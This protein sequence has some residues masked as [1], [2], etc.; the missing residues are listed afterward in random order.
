MEVHTKV[1]LELCFAFA[2]FWIILTWRCFRK[3]NPSSVAN[4]TESPPGVWWCK[5]GIAAATSC[6]LQA[7]ALVLKMWLL[8]LES[9]CFAKRHSIRS[10]QTCERCKEQIEIQTCSLL[11]A[12]ALP[13]SLQ[14][15]SRQGLR[16]NTAGT[17][18]SSTWHVLPFFQHVSLNV[19][20]FCNI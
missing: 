6:L 8:S 19:S 14:Q 10:V 3:E 16:P 7:G 17:A 13:S 5:L 2:T 18:S 11:L 1:H 12:T 9:S 20:F 4:H 15:G